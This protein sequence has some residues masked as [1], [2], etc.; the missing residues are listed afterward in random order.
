[1][2][3]VLLTG[4]LAIT[5]R[6]VW[7]AIVVRGD[8]RAYKLCWGILCSRQNCLVVPEY[9]ACKSL[10]VCHSSIVRVVMLGFF[11]WKPYY[12][13]NS[14]LRPCVLLTTLTL[15]HHK[16]LL[17]ISLQLKSPQSVYGSYFRRKYQ[18]IYW[19]NYYCGTTL[20]VQNYA[21]I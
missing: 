18:S 11:N 3:P 5:G 13:A 8:R 7:K 4:L 9:A 12:W 15:Y 20:K 16:I 2:R 14:Q 17:I 10:I 19:G 1:M 6:I 21:C